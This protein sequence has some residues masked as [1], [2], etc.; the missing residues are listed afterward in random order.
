MSSFEVRFWL[1][2]V[3]GLN[4]TRFV[5]RLLSTVDPIY[6]SEIPPAFKLGFK[7]IPVYTS[8]SYLVRPWP[9]VNNDAVAAREAQS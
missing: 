5:R 2:M 3:I 4:K 9:A 6:R 1:I 8:T 7:L